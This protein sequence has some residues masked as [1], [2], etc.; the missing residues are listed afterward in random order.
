MLSA[1]SREKTTHS[2]IIFVKY[3]LVEKKKKQTTNTKHKSPPQ[4]GE[5]K[6]IRGPPRQGSPLSQQPHP[7]GTP[8][9]TLDGLLFLLPA[10]EVDKRK[11]QHV[12]WEQ[13]LA[14]GICIVH[15]ILLKLSLF[16]PT[17]E[18]LTQTQAQVR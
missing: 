9:S 16:S 2:S 6:A 7:K 17:C 18:A 13:K 11:S 1:H 15:I 8:L 3:A 5:Q 4:G 12:T 14:S 10:M